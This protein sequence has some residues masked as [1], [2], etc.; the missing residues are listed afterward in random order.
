[1][2]IIEVHGCKERNAIESYGIRI[3]KYQFRDGTTSWSLNN[4]EYDHD[5][6][7]C[8]YC[9]LK[10]NKNLGEKQI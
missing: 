1:M 6:I 8:P 3:I 5:I 2:P 9:G 7:Y 10:L 4:S